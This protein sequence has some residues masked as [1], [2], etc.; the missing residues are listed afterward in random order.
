LGVFFLLGTVFVG[1]TWKV[2]SVLFF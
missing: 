1:V 2:V